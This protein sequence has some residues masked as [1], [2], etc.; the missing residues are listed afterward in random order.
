MCITLAHPT[1]ATFPHHVRRSSDETDHGGRFTVKRRTS[2]FDTSTFDTSTFDFLL[3]L[4][5][6]NVKVV[7]ILEERGRGRVPC[8]SC[9]VTF[10]GRELENPAPP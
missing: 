10:V 1:P 7:R 9:G 5:A 3:L 2:T 6:S 4:G 8:D